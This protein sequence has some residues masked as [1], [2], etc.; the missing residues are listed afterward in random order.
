MSLWISDPSLS[1]L[2]IK[3]INFWT[4][5]WLFRLWF[6]KVSYST[7]LFFEEFIE[8][9]K[10]SVFNAIPCF[11]CLTCKSGRQAKVLNQTWTWKKVTA[12][13]CDKDLRTH[14]AVWIWI[15][16]PEPARE[17]YVALAPR[18]DLVRSNHARCANWAELSVVGALPPTQAASS[19]ESLRKQTRPFEADHEEAVFFFLLLIATVGR[20]LY[21]VRKAHWETGSCDERA[22]DGFSLIWTARFINGLH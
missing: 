8:N 15:W 14:A 2:H 19:A 16:F 3:M 12:A 20:S 6:T 10:K 1:L 5:S 18:F 17:A 21:V 22:R 7:V 9:A 4:F 13:S 11:K